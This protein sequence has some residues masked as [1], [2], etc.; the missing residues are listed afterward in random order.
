MAYSIKEIAELAGVTTRTLRYYDEIGL[1]SP[2]E[3]GDNGY[4]LYDHQS[5]LRL[6]QI[7]YFR[8]LDIPLK[9]IRHTLNQPNFDLLTALETH[10]LSLQGRAERITA[11]I[12]TLDQTIA[13]LKGEWIM[14]EKDY[15]NGFDESQYE[16]EAR[17]RWGGTPQYSES[18]RKL[19]SYSKEKKEAIKQEGRRI[20][21]RMVG[22]DAD[23]K[24][25][26]ADVQAAVGDYFTY[27]NKN[28]YTCDVEFLR[29]LSDM[30]V[31]DPR[32]AVNYER[33]REG[34]AEFVRDAVQIY[35]D[36]QKD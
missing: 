30:W 14:S 22:K 21:E 24:P 5:M 16:E 6:Q 7:L 3:V 11:L 2:A 26:D 25:D 27:L 20:T 12:E 23:A 18:R 15:F 19:E 13:T 10:R 31:A 4:R 33:I 32:F 17:Q 28:F 1:L 35:C 29:N 36:R 34:G 9:D 8:E